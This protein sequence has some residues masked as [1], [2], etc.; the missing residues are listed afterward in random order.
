MGYLAYLT[1]ALSVV[2]IVSEARINISRRPGPSAIVDD[3]FSHRLLMVSTLASIV[4]GLAAKLLSDFLGG[5]GRIGFLSPALGYLGC[6]LI[7]GGMALR[8][9]A[10]AT[11]KDKFTVDVAIVQDH[12]IV[13]TGLYAMV[14]HPSYLGSLI[15]FIGLGLAWQNW[16]SLVIMIALRLTATLYRISVEERVLVDH[17]GEVYLTY[18]KRTKGLIPGIV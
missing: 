12:R 17:F 18:R 1:M 7:A 5:P 16:L 2:W 13:D 11:L 6:L 15:T 10:I 14:R 3:R 4:L 9:A 8:W